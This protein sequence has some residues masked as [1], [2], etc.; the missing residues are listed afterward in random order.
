M[1]ESSTFIGRLKT[2]FP[3]LIELIE[4]NDYVILEPKKKLIDKAN[5]TKVFYCNHIY[6]KSSYD[7]RLYINLNGKVLKY[8][9]PKFIT[10]LGWKK[11][12]VL[13]IK[14]SSKVLNGVQCFQ[15]DNVCDEVNYTEAKTSAIKSQLQKKKTLEEYRAYNKTLLETNSVYATVFEEKFKKFI[16]EMKNNYMFMKGYEESYSK[17]FNYKKYKLIKK[18]I[19]LLG[20]KVENYNDNFNIISELVDSL[21]FDEVTARECDPKFPG[22][23]AYLFENC[24]AKFYEEDEK[25]IIKYLK[26]NPSKYDWEGMEVDKIYY[27][28]K[29]EGAIHIL[30]NISVKKTVFE[31][32]LVLKDVNDLITEEA[33]N[34]F[35]SQEKKNFNLDGDDLLK[36]WIYVIAHSNVKNILAEAKFVGLFGS[37]GYDSDDYIAVNFVSAVQGIKDEI[38][39]IVYTLSQY[40]E[41]NK[42]SL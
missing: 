35:E 33:K 34:I 38:L 3:E 8:E 31:K 37:G 41:S 11:N 18:F 28:C 6:Y 39:K 29:F 16:K 25:K 4:K 27:N 5:T 40:V 24:L 36:F 7:D 23:Y 19:E 12:M 21:V 9:H 14:D 42:I 17:I 2:N 1:S 13:T 20:N 26:D 22:L 15:L 30:E 10:Y 32:K